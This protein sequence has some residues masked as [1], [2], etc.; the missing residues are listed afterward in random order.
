MLNLFNKIIIFII[1]ILF[2]S[3]EITELKEEERKVI[4]EV[5]GELPLHISAKKFVFS[6]EINNII[7]NKSL[8][9]NKVN[10]SKYLP[11]N[12]DTCIYLYTVSDT[13]TK[14]KHIKLSE[15]DIDEKYLINKSKYISNISLFSESDTLNNFLDSNF[16]F[17]FVTN[18]ESYDVNDLNNLENWDVY[19]G[20]FKF[21]RVYFNDR[22]NKA[23]FYCRYYCSDE[24][25]SGSIVFVE[26]VSGDWKIKNVS[27][28]FIF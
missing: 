4:L 3:S 21:G 24:C 15:L 22:K 5:M 23:F 18:I 1:W 14:L 10:Y 7:I 25:G 20:S 26:K 11:G 17:V 9:K 6:N 2:G 27:T 8:N 19:L 13:L 28:Y 12:C 16:L